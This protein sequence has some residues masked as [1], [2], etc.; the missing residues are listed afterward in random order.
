MA[1][2]FHVSNGLRGGYMPDASG[3]YMFKTRRELKDYLMC[4]R[5]GCAAD[6]EGA[7]KAAIARI[8]AQAWRNA[9]S[10][11]PLCLPLKPAGSSSYSYGIFISAASR[12][13]YLAYLRE[14][15]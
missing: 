1:K 9:P 2:Y 15:N 11:L 5:D 14:C 13:D 4:E 3:V 7:S 6:C 12:A 10:G 8:A